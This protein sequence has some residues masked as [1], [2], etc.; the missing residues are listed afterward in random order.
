MG[1]LARSSGVGI[2]IGKIQGPGTAPKELERVRAGDQLNSPKDVE[3]RQGRGDRDRDREQ[4]IESPK[5]RDGSASQPQLTSQS[6]AQLAQSQNQGQSRGSGQ[7]ADQDPRGSPQYH[8]PLGIP[9]E[10]HASPASSLGYTQYSGT[11]RRGVTK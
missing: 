5:T 11:N 9:Q 1:G 2:G 10:Q 3:R 7:S 4:R 8:T 6:Q